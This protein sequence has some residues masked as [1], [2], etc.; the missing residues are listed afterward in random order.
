MKAIASKKAA[1]AITQWVALRPGKRERIRLDL[2]NVGSASTPPRRVYRLTER[3][4]DKHGFDLLLPV[5]EIEDWTTMLPTNFSM[6]DII[7]LYC[8]HAT[9]EQF[10]AEFKSGMD[11]ARLPSGKFD[12][13]SLVCQLAALAMILL[14]LIGQNT[15]NEPDTPVRHTANRLRIRSVMQE[16][17]FKAGRM[18]KHAGR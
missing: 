16:M 7:A 17:M 2:P 4:I 10:H 3:T 1:D 8:D 6:I 15:L 14:R 12:A 9:H 13:N 11:L 18:I 5:N